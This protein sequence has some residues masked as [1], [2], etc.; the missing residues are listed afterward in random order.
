MW[1]FFYEF[2]FIQNF[3]FFCV[4]CSKWILGFCLPM[5]FSNP[6]KLLNLL[7]CAYLQY[8]LIIIVLSAECMVM[9]PFSFLNTGN[10]C[11]LSVSLP[12]L[13]MLFSLENNF[14]NLFKVQIFCFVS[15]IC[16]FINQFLLFFLLFTFMSLLNIKTYQLFG[17][18]SF[19]IT[20]S[21]L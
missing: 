3:Y 17:P 9:L 16:F 20:Y 2:R 11:S 7:S 13:P 19:P 14:I 21:K 6:S 8:L 10:L 4:G 12:L 1:I 15:F 18:F 5:T